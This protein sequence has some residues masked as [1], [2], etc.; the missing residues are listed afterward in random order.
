MYTY[1]HYH[2]ER[3]NTRAH[4]SL[5]ET[6]SIVAVFPYMI[7]SPFFAR[8]L[9]LI[10]S[11]RE[12]STSCIAGASTIVRP[13]TLMFACAKTQSQ[14]CSTLPCKLGC[15]V[16]PYGLELETSLKPCVRLD[17]LQI[18]SLASL[19]P[20]Q[21]VAGYRELSLQHD[22]RVELVRP[23]RLL[24]AIEVRKSDAGVI[25]VLR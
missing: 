6:S 14:S 17:L 1:P 21:H 7:H 22:E 18:R 23:A 20:H 15:S 24:V 10:H 4:G 13:T 16:A 8:Q 19:A 3:R 12:L 5:T 9:K 25:A 11:G 2:T